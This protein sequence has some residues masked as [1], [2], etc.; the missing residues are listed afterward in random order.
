MSSFLF[1]IPFLA[2]IAI[3]FGSPARLTARGAAIATFLLGLFAAAT[4]DNSALWSY[5]ISALAIPSLDI[6]FGFLNGTSAVMV[7]LAVIVMLAA[8]FTGK[9]PEGRINCI[10]LPAY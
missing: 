7:A 8:V 5:K 3:I 4:Y 9:A 1:L 6:A 2:A 10:S